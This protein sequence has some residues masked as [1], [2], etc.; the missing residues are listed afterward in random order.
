[1]KN[2][3][4]G[5]VK[6]LRCFALQAAT[7]A[8]LLLLI[9]SHATP[10]SAGTWTP[11]VNRP[12]FSSIQIMIL[13]T[14]GSIMVQTF[15]DIQT[16]AKLTPDAHGSYINGTWVTLGKMITP[17]LYFTSDVLQNGNLWVMGGE[18]TGPF[19]DANWGPQAEIYNPLTN[20]WTEAA[21][22]P[23]QEGCGYVPVTSDVSLTTGS[24]VINGIYST[25]RM[26]TGWTVSGPG[27]PAK[28]TV[29]AV[30]SPTSVT[31]SAAATA[32]GPAVAGFFG[33]AA[34][35]F[36]DDPSALLPRGEILAGDLISPQSFLY[37]IAENA[38]TETGTKV[39]NDSSDEEGWAMIPSGQVVNYDL[40]QSIAANT[41]YAEE[42]TPSTG[43][44]T[45]ISPA[46]G[47]AR[48]TLPVLS[49]RQVGYELGPIL[50]LLDGRVLVIGANQ[51]T[52][53]YTPS[54]DRWEPGPDMI[55]PL[56]GPGGTIPDA[57]FGADDAPA[58]ILPN[59]HVY[60]IADSGPNPVSLDA[61]TTAGS[62]SVSVPTTA[63]LQP[64]WSVAQADGKK[65]TIPPG[66]YIY[67]VDSSTSFTLGAYNS[68]GNL[69]P[70]NALQTG[71]LG[72]VLGGIFSSPSQ[73]FDFDPRAGTMTPIPAPPGS[74][75]P[76]EGAYV[77]RML[78]L[79]TGQLMLSDSS[80]Q[81]Y[82]YTPDASHAYTPHGWGQGSLL[83]AIFH[84]QYTGGGVFRLT[85]TQ[86]NGQ[87]DGSA[88]GDDDQMNENFPVV[89]LED[90]ATGNVYYCR[91]TNWSSVSVAGGNRPETVDFTLN[92]A[93]TAG[94]YELT[95]VGAGL[96]SPPVRIEITPN[97][98]RER[99]WAVAQP[100]TASSM[101]ATAPAAAPAKMR[102]VPTPIHR[103]N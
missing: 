20:T 31:I 49:D 22:D 55:A 76:D 52:A 58:A 74:F 1:M 62:A 30:T 84:V 59:G 25:F 10:A 7:F 83:P 93:V 80:N 95:V 34:S 100:A 67:S 28:A 38:F 61:G 39:Y 32:S 50:R 82:V 46:D 87:S 15:D 60:L 44:W 19:E 65:T 23:P 9:S 42:Y 91:T 72:L 33:P 69:A 35:C 98:V 45:S 26:Q 6:R 79:P 96:A 2:A 68:S 85:G 8:A 18:Y 71:T 12:S 99:S 57:L 17:R 48:G 78:V 27:I 36:G 90:P 53:L 101:L 103:H 14:D 40:F 63:G 73:L 13:M 3:I 64:G 92:P 5:L 16:W 102:H 24:P 89:R 37:S 94:R 51:H 88:Y 4:N 66:T 21:S 56:T 41:G 11:L 97:E 70:I 77:T 47:T 81:L 54:S 29:V 86:L 43:F 75:L